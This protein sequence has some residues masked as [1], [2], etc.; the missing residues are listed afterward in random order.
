[1]LEPTLRDT[2]EEAGIQDVT[3]KHDNKG[4]VGVGEFPGTERQ[5]RNRI[6]TQLDVNALESAD[7]PTVVR[8]RPLQ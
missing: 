2:M 8:C 4:I 3:I 6:G 7:E 5:L 1:M